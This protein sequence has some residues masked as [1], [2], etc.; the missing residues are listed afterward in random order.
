MKKFT[1]ELFYLAFMI[2]LADDTHAWMGWRVVSARIRPKIV[3]PAR[4]VFVG[5]AVIENKDGGRGASNNRE[6]RAVAL[7][8]NRL[9]REF[10][11][12]QH[13]SWCLHERF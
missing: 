9:W 12:W 10:N 3:Q 1:E 13:L 6:V 2:L 4:F 7:I 8:Q 5:V 11:P